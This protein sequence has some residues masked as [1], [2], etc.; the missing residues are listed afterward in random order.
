MRRGM[1]PWI[2]KLQIEKK[3]EN[4]VKGSEQVI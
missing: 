4:F 3:I 2:I 1:R